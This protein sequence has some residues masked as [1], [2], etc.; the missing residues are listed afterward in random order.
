MECK[1]EENH[2]VQELQEE[3]KIRLLTQHLK[4]QKEHERMFRRYFHSSKFMKYINECFLNPDCEVERV[5]DIYTTR[6]TSDTYYQ[7]MRYKQNIEWDGALYS[8]ML[9]F[10]VNTPDKLLFV[11]DMNNTTN[12][13]VGIG[14]VRNVLAKDQAINIY[15]NPSFNNYI[16]K[17]TYYISLAQ[18]CGSEGDDE[19]DD[20]GWQ[21]FIED[22]LEAKLFYGKSHSK[23]GGSF[24]VFPRKF[25]KRK[26]ILFLI[27][28]FVVLNP[29]N[30]V[31]NVM[32]KVKF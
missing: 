14:I 10:P 1:Q 27:S 19:Q 6:F 4:L 22:E 13:I 12:K 16:Y 23:R 31:D 18:I 7:N 24:M 28:L 3:H 9:M 26:H 21:Q 5:Y 17:S 11:L 15:S 30:F 20:P 32:N 8:T 25:K 2:D 29:N